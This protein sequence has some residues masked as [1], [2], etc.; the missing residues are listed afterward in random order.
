MKF[1]KESYVASLSLKT[2]RV[3]RFI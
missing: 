2:I 3:W 1:T